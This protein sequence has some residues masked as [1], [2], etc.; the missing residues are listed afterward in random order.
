M[1]RNHPPCKHSDHQ[2]TFLSPSINP[3]F[4]LRLKTYL[5]KNKI[6]NHL[7]QKDLFLNGYFKFLT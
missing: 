4:I 3:K 5:V 7:E 2:L 1:I 6:L